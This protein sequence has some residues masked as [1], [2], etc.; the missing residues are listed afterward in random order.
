[1]TKRHTIQRTRDRNVL[2]PNRLLLSLIP[3]MLC[4][5]ATAQTAPDAGRLLEILKAPVIIV[6]PNTDLKIED[7]ASQRKLIAP[8][9][10][11]GPKVKISGFKISGLSTPLKAD[12]GAL[13]GKYLGPERSFDD[14]EAAAETLQTAIRQEGL[15]LAQVDIPP[16]KMTDGTVELRV[17][18]GRLDKV[19]LAPLPDGLLVNRD[20]I[21]AMLAK[22][23][24]GDLLTVDKIERVLFLLSDLRGINVSSVISAGVTP[25]TAKL[26]VT[27]APGDRFEKNIDFDN[28]GSV[29]TG[30]HR[31]SA[32][33]S[34]NSP[35][36]RGD[37]FK[38]SGNLSTNGGVAFVRA[39]YQSPVGGT[40]LKLGA[41]ISALKYK[42]G[43]TAF[44][45]LKASGDA[46]VYSLF[47]LYPVVRSRNFNT[48]AQA[49]YDRRYFHDVQETIAVNNYKHSDVITL[50]AVGDS[51]DQIATGGINN[52]SLGLT[53]GKIAI[54]T[55]IQLAAD[56]AATGRKT[57][58]GFGKLSYGLGRQQL[59]WSKADNTQNR[60]VV[61]VSL[62]GQRAT[63][64]LDNSEKFSLGGASGVRGYAAGEATGDSGDLLSW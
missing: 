11:Q 9:T 15:F 62:Q 6:P 42:L 31:V 58:G 59:L 53:A 10:G 12:I 34:V 38:F 16:Q 7:N 13:L 5:V 36:G 37:L 3:L 23:Q 1:M 51:R 18:E 14:L 64:N 40:G 19:E 26:G 2:R 28:Y 50:G 45:P 55:P 32:S 20:Q 30:E 60:L 49:N 46:S 35:M 25:G 52:F 41:A 43:T 24:P 44:E 4:T 39:A 33:V 57:N 22:L 29:Y 63:K 54:E 47:A 48:F 21:E 56:Q 17:L 61:Y 8:T 27:V